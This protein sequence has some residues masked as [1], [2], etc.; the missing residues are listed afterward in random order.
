[1]APRVEPAQK[2]VVHKLCEIRMVEGHTWTEHGMRMACRSGFLHRVCID[3]N[4]SDSQI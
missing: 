3:S 4:H 2:V 1:M